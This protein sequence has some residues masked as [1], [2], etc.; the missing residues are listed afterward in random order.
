[1]ASSNGDF[2]DTGHPSALVDTPES[3]AHGHGG[4]GYV[5]FDEYIDIQLRKAGSTIK[6]TDV[7]TAVVGAGTLLTTY[8]LIF[9]VLDQWLVPGGFSATSR[10]LLL[11]ALLVGVAGWIGWKVLWPWRRRVNGLYSASTI[12]KASPG[13]KGSL[14]N[15]IDLLRAEREIPPEIY[16]SLER[17][18]A[19]A[20]T[21][22]DVRESVDRHLLLRLSMALF[23]VVVLFCG[24]WIFSPKNPASS[25]WRAIAPA[26]DATVATRTKIDLVRPGDVDVVARSQVDVTAEV[27]GQMPQQAT[28]Y[29]TTAD[30]KFVDERIDAR[31]TAEASREFHFVIN[32]DNGAGILQDM[33]Y[34][35]V[36]GDDSSRDYKIHVIQPPAATID[37]IRLDYP[38][39]TRLGT[40]T[41]ATGAIDALEGTRVTLH[42]TANMPLRS[43]SVQFFDDES[44]SKR[45][46][47]VPVHIESG[48]KLVAEWTLQMRS[49]GTYAH[50]YRIFCTSVGGESERAPSLYS[51]E[52]RA[53]RPPEIVL[54]DP[55]TDLE[56]PANAELPL[57]FEARDPDFALT[58]INLKIEKDGASVIGPEIYDGHDHPDQHL[59]KSYKWS[60]K[61]YHFRPKETI[62]YWLEA[63]DNRKPLA[64]TTG[65]SPRLRIRITDP[66]PES[67]V[68]KDFDLA[69]NRQR[70]EAKHSDDDKNTQPKPD[71]DPDATKPGQDRPKPQP[72]EKQQNANS[73]QAEKPADQQ[74]A[75]QQNPDQQN[76]TG[77]KGSGGDGESKGSGAGDKGDKGT[78][79][80]GQSG[81]NGQSQKPNP[82][83]PSSDPKAL[84]TM[85]DHFQKEGD[86]GGNGSESKPQDGNKDSKGKNGDDKS[87]EQKRE[88]TGSQSPQDGK[89]PN[90]KPENQPG[91]PGAKPQPGSQSNPQSNSPDGQNQ[92]DGKNQDGK[93]PDG[94]EGGSSRDLNQPR[95]PQ[96]QIP[97]GGEKNSKDKDANVNPKDN[98]A[99]DNNAKDNNAKDNNA[100]DKKPG[101]G[102]GENQPSDKSK[103]DKQAG[104]QPSSERHAP[105]KQPAD[106]EAAQKP[107]TGQNSEAGKKPEPGQK[108]EAGQQGQE[109]GQQKPG[110]KSQTASKEARDG[111]EKGQPSPGDQSSSDKKNQNTGRSSDSN[112]QPD[113]GSAKP[114]ASQNRSKGANPGD[115]K[116]QRSQS[117]NPQQDASQRNNAQDANDSKTSKPADEQP[118]G[119]TESAAKNQDR[120]DA[121]KNADPTG[122]TGERTPQPQQE[123]G[124]KPHPGQP[125]DS[126]Q[127]FNPKETPPGEKP[128]AKAA[129]RRPNNR[130]PEENDKA[131]D[132]DTDKLH[133]K[134]MRDEKQSNSKGDEQTDVGKT[135]DTKRTLDKDA[136]LSQKGTE[137]EG[138]KQK[139]SEQ[140]PPSKDG[141]EKPSQKDQSGKER[142]GQEG[143]PPKPA[144]ES[145]QGQPK[146]GQPGQK[147]Q[148]GQNGQETQ[149]AKQ[150]QA[151]KQAKEGQPGQ[152]GDG[153]PGQPGGQQSGDQGGG[154]KPSKPG[155][156]T[157]SG[158][159]NGN[160]TNTG[161]GGHNNGTG[162]GQGEGLVNTEKEANLD[163][164]RK[165][166]DLILNRLQGQLSRGKVD[167]SLL[168][169]LGWTKD[170]VRRFVERMRRQA[171]SEQGG[172][173]PADE[174]RRL[175][176]E[177]TLRSL[178]LKQLPRS[179]SGIGV[180]KVGGLEMENRRSVPPPEFRELYDAYTKSLSNSQT[181]REKK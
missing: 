95:Q 110:D 152:Q 82:D 86:K 77:D 89:S 135:G 26:S 133:G 40:S 17:R 122:R 127:N 15:L 53:D 158:M 66:V 63:Q 159:G 123:A 16:K 22:V 35:V 19:V 27:R 73:V 155:Q 36:A 146:D 162:N 166:T 10:L 120:K 71:E 62:T 109:Q 48:N 129:K 93:K 117:G 70:E 42:A 3:G 167:E 165:A 33:T 81:Q 51:V 80:G 121:T 140:G 41:Q 125:Q 45:A 175:Q 131:I 124:A 116:D 23:A 78:G 21:H 142:P 141:Q 8:L 94:K 172:T 107:E 104:A 25:L 113:Q 137:N 7:M 83:D 108:S 180:K 55:K 13:F 56:L 24:Y 115:R 151:A 47:E 69:E 138:A 168:K 91:Q 179:R 169:E 52:I 173:T 160:G 178:E 14:V 139:T 38:E 112:S 64:N 157:A 96:S 67:Q 105:D 20:L 28:L 111:K 174:A 118:G 177:E 12:E 1:M 134:S 4:D 49:D 84:Q 74:P 61:E 54:L 75:E 164:A 102:G 161:G 100:R 39:Y 68:K 57:L 98:N 154:D 106:K 101:E 130:D 90:D 6:S 92:P 2:P 143:G 144:Q 114:D 153:K 72:K 29:Y 85:H 156:S 136:P 148:P 18:A 60:L 171:Q 149:S 176:W 34:R 119:K 5:D 32:G 103:P 50:F 37:S 9:I 79:E 44:A 88:Q 46:E 76:K 31:P 170:E 181:P 30:H 147:G 43:A 11:S 145:P 59:K 65:T 58:Y 163:Y 97:A 87:G 99:K 132:K 126:P 150:G 128:D